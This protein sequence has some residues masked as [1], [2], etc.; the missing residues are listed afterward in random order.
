ML[1]VKVFWPISRQI[2]KKPS[3]T[4][5]E[6]YDRPIYAPTNLRGEKQ[7]RGGGRVNEGCNPPYDGALGGLSDE[8]QLDGRLGRV[9]GRRT[10]DSDR[11]ASH[12]GSA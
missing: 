9:E 4:S 11:G 10:I 7:T 6:Q 2:G 8:F 12:G 5:Y 3:P 1:K